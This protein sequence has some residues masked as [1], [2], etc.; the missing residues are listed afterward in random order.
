MTARWAS[1][2]S[3]AAS[4]FITSIDLLGTMAKPRICSTESVASMSTNRTDV[5]YKSLGG[6][7]HQ[8]TTH[9]G[10]QN[11]QQGSILPTF[12]EVRCSLQN[13][14]VPNC[15]ITLEVV[16]TVKTHPWSKPTK[17]SVRMAFHVICLHTFPARNSM[18]VSASCSGIK[19]LLRDRKYS[20]DS[21]MQSRFTSTRTSRSL[22]T[23]WRYPAVSPSGVR[24]GFWHHEWLPP[25]SSSETSTIHLHKVAEGCWPARIS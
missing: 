21:R 11:L 23:Q 2:S 4:H 15:R 18:P 12:A 22:P 25:S 8:P 24:A 20:G 19:A 10:W 3:L 17:A 13:F 1:S 9:S 6:G 5:N 7:P 16:S 14:Q